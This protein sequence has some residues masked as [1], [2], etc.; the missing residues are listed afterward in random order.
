MGHA[1]TNES[2]SG[3]SDGVFV[4]TISGRWI[5]L[6]SAVQ[7]LYDTSTSPVAVSGMASVESE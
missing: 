5:W 1:R 6:Q 4:V 7:F 2:M 3:K